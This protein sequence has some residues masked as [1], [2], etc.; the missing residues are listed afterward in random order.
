MIPN[1]SISIE[2]TTVYSDTVKDMRSPQLIEL[3]AM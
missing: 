1:E 3:K 2:H